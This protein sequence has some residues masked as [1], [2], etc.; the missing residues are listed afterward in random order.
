MNDENNKDYLN[1]E[2]PLKKRI[3]SLVS[4][5]TLEEKIGL[6]P[7]S[8]A[9]IP[10]L[11]IKAYGIGNEV[12]RGYV[13]HDS[14]KRGGS[15]N[16][17]VFPQPIGLASMF[18]TELLE[19]L[20]EIAGTELRYY[21]EHT[22][23][24]HLVLF[25]PTVDLAR[26]PRWGR[27]EEC[28]GEDPYLAGQSVKAYTK[29]I[30]GNNPDYYRAVPSLKHFFANNNEKDRSSS[31]SN[32]DPRTKFEYY[33]RAFKPA[34][35]SGYAAGVMTSYNSINGLPALFNPDLERVCKRQWGMKYALTDGGDMGQTVTHHHF[36]R[37]HAKTVAMAI[38]S[39]TDIMCDDAELVKDSLRYA[40]DKG[41]LSEKDLDKAVTNA[42][43]PRFLLGEFNPDENNPY[44]NLPESVVNSFKYKVI[45]LQAAREAITLLKNQSLL[46]LKADRIK[47]LAVLG[48]HG[49][50][51]FRD[52]YTGS[53]SY[54][55]TVFDAFKGMLPDSEV[56]YDDC[57]DTV[58]IRSLFTGK[59]LRVNDDE[60]ITADGESSDNE[61][62]RFIKD[63]W[64]GEIV[65]T[66]VKNGK[67]I[68][69]EKGY[70]ASEES[71]Y[72][73][74]VKPIIK[75]SMVKGDVV[76]KSWN[77]K[78]VFVDD[79]GR[80]TC[81]DVSRVEENQLFAE[82]IVDDGIVRGMRLAADCDY[83]IVCVGNNPMI[84]AREC[85]DRDN[86]ELPYFQHEF[87]KNIFMANR[88][89]V[90]CLISSYPYAITELDR[91]LPAIIYT[92]HGGPEMGTAVAETIL[93]KNNPAGR[94]PMT[95]YSSTQELASI[96][97]YDI[98]NSKSTY[99]YYDRKP[100]YPFGYGLSYSHFRYG[101]LKVTDSTETLEVSVT[102]ENLSSLGGD[103]V[104]QVYISQLDRR[105]KR[106]LKQLCG[107]KR[108]FIDPIEKKVFSFSIDKKEFGRWDAVMGEYCFDEGMYRIFAGGSSGDD[109]C[110]ATIF[111][112]G[113]KPAIREAGR[114]INAV[115]CDEKSGAEIRSTFDGKDEYIAGTYT[116]GGY[117]VFYDLDFSNGKG[118]KVK[119]STNGN[120]SKLF[121]AVEGENIAELELPPF[122]D[123][124][125]FKTFEIPFIKEIEGVHDLTVHLREG[126]NVLSLRIISE[127]DNE[128]EKPKSEEDKEN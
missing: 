26:D 19:K 46:P 118:I 34:I 103:E 67:Y 63:D 113:T 75:P 86:I 38:K 18:D 82:E 114:K 25:G 97:D 39:G 88:N 109:E 94:T 6:I 77:G 31:S 50:E 81:G 89:T 87:V 14:E 51:Y 43:Y 53:S 62:C 91:L 65:L 56:E 15:E 126:V 68:S 112:T 23:K 54:S 22:D 79:E 32:I 64:G 59:Y 9:A 60:T 55:I 72:S 21:E 74:F 116:F 106:P 35:E 61:D 127:K 41:M 120:A 58:A 93:G 42:L 7:T 2:L 101:S 99:L 37:N 73:W 16:S 125:K 70:T 90:M 40:L 104:V 107:F 119:A 1:T 52:W 29:G 85:Y 98:I 122:V 20:G 76:Y 45:N 124:E 44:L 36:T 28:Y 110:S 100:L 47:K 96:N 5:L 3:K 12:A 95:W 10:R 78:T 80:L 13:P 17:T 24:N 128:E 69:A 11:G 108:A 27:N 30:V 49:N 105:Y 57:R 92:A 111:L 8:Q 115:F 33:Y 71:L 121:F 102:V 48:V 4:Q 123:P 83:A 117:V 84:V 66:S